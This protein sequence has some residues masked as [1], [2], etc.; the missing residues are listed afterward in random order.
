MP[1]IVVRAGPAEE[2]PSRKWC[3]REDC[4]RET[5]YVQSQAHFDEVVVIPFYRRAAEVTRWSMPATVLPLYCKMV[6]IVSLLSREYDQVR[7][8]DEVAKCWVDEVRMWAGAWK[9]ASA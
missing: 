4:T 9:T 5:C 6:D 1:T 7:A 3:T 2:F 8:R